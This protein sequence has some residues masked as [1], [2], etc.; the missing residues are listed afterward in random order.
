MAKIHHERAAEQH[1]GRRAD[2]TQCPAC[3]L[4]RQTQD[5]GVLRANASDHDRTDRRTYSEEENAGSSRH[6]SPSGPTSDLR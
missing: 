5:D 3:R 2:T 1:D 4:Q 6:G